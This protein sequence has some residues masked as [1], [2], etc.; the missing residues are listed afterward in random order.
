MV[1]RHMATSR[2]HLAVVPAHEHDVVDLA[3]VREAQAHRD[4]PAKLPRYSPTTSLEKIL[5]SAAP[6]AAQKLDWNEGTIAPPPSVAAAMVAHIQAGDGHFLKWYP[7]LSGGEDLQHELA[8]YCGVAVE[9]L[10]ITNG[11]DDAL[12][13]L[14]HGLLGHGKTA[15]APTP[16]YEHF[17]V[18]VAGTGAGLIR[19]E[20]ADP[21]TTDLDALIAGVA[22]HRPQ[23]VYLVSPNNPTG[24]QWAADDVRTLAVRFPEVTFVVDEAYHEFASLDPVTG[25]PMTCAPL[26]AAFRNVVVTRTFSKAFCLAS[27]RCGY[28]IAHPAT[29]DELRPFYNPKSVNQLAQVAAAA[30]LR[31][32]DSYYRPYV[33]ATHEARDAFVVDLRDRGVDVRTGGAGNFVCIRVPEGRTAELCKRLE[34]DHIYVRDIA[35]RF[36]GYVRITIGLEMDRVAAAVHSALVAMGLSRTIS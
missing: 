15:L 34:D 13:L 6:F 17:C 31:E 8:H 21:F 14:C 9:N 30:A 12:I 22:F 7:Q 20:Q 23:L 5:R 3:A 16:T 32:F 10:L 4:Q 11:S 36:P 19:F 28:V 2:A 29:L 1:A 35:S 33:A 27:V 25:K 18:N 24:T 26:A